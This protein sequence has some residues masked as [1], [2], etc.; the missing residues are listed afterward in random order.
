MTGDLS[1]GARN[2]APR[3]MSR[4][5]DKKAQDSYETDVV[6]AQHE[7]R[8]AQFTYAQALQHKRHLQG[9]ANTA[10]DVVIEHDIERQD[11]IRQLDDQAKLRTSGGLDKIENA[12][13]DSL[14]LAIRLYTVR[15]GLRS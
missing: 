15:V 8:V 1:R 10:E 14:G 13:H 9:L 12:L 2:Q 7:Q 5:G 6:W 3:R 11:K 4:A